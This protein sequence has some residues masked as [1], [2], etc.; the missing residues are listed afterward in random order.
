MQEI[1]IKDSMTTKVQSATPSSPLSDVIRA[2]KESPHSCLVITENEIPVGIVTE[3][4]IVRLADGLFGNHISFT[5]PV[6]E[7]MSQPIITID[8]NANLLDALV[9]A[10]SKKV[11]HLPVDNAQGKLVGLVTQSD[12]VSAQFRLHKMQ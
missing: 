10:K 4:D 8:A 6:K 9:V 11:R 1:R 2:M 12:L 3:R 5:Q 7:F